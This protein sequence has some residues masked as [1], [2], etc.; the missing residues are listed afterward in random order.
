MSFTDAHRVAC[1]CAHGASSHISQGQLLPAPQWKRR[2]V[3]G[4]SGLSRFAHPD[5][6]RRPV[7][8]A[9]V[10]ALARASGPRA[11]S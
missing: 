6:C 7:A 9:G 3:W 4:P 1:I 2:M 8:G 11:Q 5:S 10:G